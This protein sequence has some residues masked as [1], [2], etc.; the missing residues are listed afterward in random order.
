MSS[1]LQ[2]NTSPHASFY[3]VKSPTTLLVLNA[4]SYLP[5]LSASYG[6][7]IATQRMVDPDP[8]KW[9]IPQVLE[10]D[11]AEQNSAG[12]VAML[13]FESE[14][15]LKRFVQAGSLKDPDKKKKK[16]RKQAKPSSTEVKEALLKKWSKSLYQSAHLLKLHSDAIVGAYE[17][18]E[19]APVVDDDG[20]TTVRHASST[21]ETRAGSLRT[22]A[23][24]RKRKKKRLLPED[25]LG[26]FYKFQNKEKRGREREE[27][28]RGWERDREEVKK[29]KKAG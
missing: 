2:L 6:F 12:D 25:G 3:S 15:S 7:T 9:T 27:L 13:N 18:S 24:K 1:F 5:S 20:W 23:A 28:R 29:R 11:S 16:K 21:E 26:N 19:S 4:P 17:A 10:D 22:E 14:A 8:S